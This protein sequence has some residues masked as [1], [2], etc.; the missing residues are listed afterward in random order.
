MRTPANKACSAGGATLGLLVTAGWYLSGRIGFAKNPATIEMP[1]FGTNSRAMESPSFVA[2]TAYSLELLMLRTDKYL[3]VTFGIATVIGV[4]L[5][6]LVHAITSRQ[7]RWKRSASFEDLRNHLMGGMLM[8]FGGV[9][10]IACTIGQGVTGV[11][12]LALGSLKSVAGIVT[13]AVAN[14]KWQQR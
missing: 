8:G 10:V 1:H 3:H 9:L 5:G 12:T 7:L 2:P 13:G 11:S 4:V 14:I 6:S